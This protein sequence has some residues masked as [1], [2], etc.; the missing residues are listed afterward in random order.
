MCGLVDSVQPL[1][2]PLSGGTDV[3]ITGR[4]LSEVDVR[5]VY[6]GE[7]RTRFVDQNAYKW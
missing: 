1:Y 2:G 7:Y 3:T 6:F 5:A 4:F